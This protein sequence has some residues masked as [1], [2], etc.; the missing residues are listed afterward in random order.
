MLMIGVQGQCPDEGKTGKYGPW[1]GGFGASKVAL[2]EATSD[3]R[4]DHY[5][6]KLGPERVSSFPLPRNPRC[7]GRSEDRGSRVSDG[8]TT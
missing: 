1:A 8:R 2:R 6:P 5:V 7:L 4:G 3:F